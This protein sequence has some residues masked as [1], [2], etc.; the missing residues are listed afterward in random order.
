MFIALTGGIGCGKS[1][2]LECFAQCGAVICDADKICHSFYET[3]DGIAAVSQRWPSVI[4]EKN[5]LDRQKLAN[6]V[7]RDEDALTALEALVTPYLH[8]KLLELKNSQLDIV[9]EVPLL[10]EKSMADFFDCTAAVWSPFALR[11]QRLAQRNWDHQECARRERLQWTPEKKL[12]AA[13]YGII[14]T[15][16]KEMLSQQCQLIFRQIK[17]NKTNLI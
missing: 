9:V 2:A 11:R 13:D 3:A 8:Q 17:K 5:Q 7:F 14:N 10:F 1:T 12:A 15:G 6:I 16:S 4:D